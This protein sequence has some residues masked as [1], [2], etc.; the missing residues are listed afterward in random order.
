MQA[1]RLKFLE[2][3]LRDNPDDPF[4][5]YALALEYLKSDRTVAA[6]YFETLENRFP[7]YLPAYYHAAAFCFEAGDWERADRLYR[8]GIDLAGKTGHTK[9]QRELQGA[10]QLFKDETD[11]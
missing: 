6:R 9:A 8:A 11:E 3:D 5:Y 1:E 4:N 10:Y 7:D 2:E